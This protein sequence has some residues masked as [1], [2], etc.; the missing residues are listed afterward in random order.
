MLGVRW[1]L[2]CLPTLGMGQTSI[3]PSPAAPAAG[4]GSEH[5][6]VS[7]DT[8]ANARHFVA[9][10]LT[11][12]NPERLLPQGKRV[13]PLPTHAT[14]ALQYYPLTRMHPTGCSGVYAYRLF[15]ET[16]KSPLLRDKNGQHY[17]IFHYFVLTGGQL[18][19]F[20]TRDVAANERKFE[21]LAPSLCKELNLRPATVD[22]L[23]QCLGHGY[24]NQY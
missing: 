24:V 18:T 14:V 5:T 16:W 17:S 13:T 7:S 11:L 9:T 15:S 8:S 23:K 22:S 20:N 10:C 21:Q 3:G 1:L 4:K 19:V 12:A 6:W 2:C